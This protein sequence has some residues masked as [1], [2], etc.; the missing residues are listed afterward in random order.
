MKRYFSFFAVIF[1]FAITLFLAEVAFAQP[2]KISVKVI[3]AKTGEPVV[4]ATV[5]VVET[6]QGAYTKDNGVATIINVAPGQNYTV[7]AK[8]AGFELSTISNVKV[9]SNLTTNLEFK[10]ST[11][12]QKEI[13]VEARPIV[14]KSETK[15]GARFDSSS[16]TNVPGRKN[17]TDLVTLTPG[18]VAE[19]QGVTIAG[20]RSTSNSTRMG[21]VEITDIVDGNTNSIQS[22][23]ST[24]AVAELNVTTSGA[25]ASRGN[26]TGGYIESNTKSG[27]ASFE[28]LAHY[29]QEIPALFGSSSN[30][31]EL[32][33]SGN[34][35]LEVAFG[36]PIT[37]DAK[38]FVTVKGSTTDY[39]RNGLNVMDPYGNNLGQIDHTKQF[40]RAITA[41]LAFNDVFGFRVQADAILASESTQI[42][43]TGSGINATLNNIFTYGDLPQLPALNN[44]NNL[45]T[46]KGQSQIGEGIL[47]LTAGFETV[48]ERFG[49]YD[50]EAGG[51]LFSPYK[52]YTPKDEY[53][54]D[55]ITG[56][57]TPGKDGIMDNY[58]PVSKQIPDPRNPANALN[59]SGA[60]LNPFTGRIE[61]G[62]QNYTTNNPYGLMN[63]FYSVGNPAGY[64]EDTRQRIQVDGK[65]AQQISE[66][67]IT[68][69]F[70]GQFH[71]ITT[72]SNNL[73]WDANPFQDVYDVNPYTAAL[74]VI[75][76]ME[77]ADIT[78]NP[79]LRFDI[80]DPA[81]NTAIVDPYNPVDLDDTG[82]VVYSFASA[83]IQ[84]QLSPRLGITYAISEMTTFNFNYGLYF[85]QPLMDQ[86]LT[87]TGG[88]FYKVLQRGNQIIGNGNLKAERSTEIVVGFTTA[89]NDIL[90]MTVQGVYKD[91]RNQSGLLRISSP[92]LATGYTMYIDDQYGNAKS[93]MLSFDKR[94][95]DNYAI[96]FN[97]TYSTAKGTSSS[98]A[99]NYSRLINPP[100]GAETAVLPLQ[101]YPLG[102]DRPIVS[103]LIV[104]LAWQK[105]EGP[106]IFG[107]KL[108]ELFNLSFTTEYRDGTP[109][110]PEDI[111]GNQSGEFNSARRPAYF[112]TNASLSR[113]IPL[114]DIFGDGAG[115]T[116]IDLQLEVLNLFNRTQAVDVYAATGLGDDDGT[117]GNFTGTVV[118]KNDPT[119]ADGNQLDALGNLKYNTRWDLNKDGQVDLSE[120]QK[121]FTQYR[122]DNY[123][124]RTNYQVPLRTYFNVT[125]RF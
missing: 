54:Y 57:L 97:F 26:A 60:G 75:D 19:G 17:L 102:Y 45:F 71:H 88:D 87:N 31:Y 125:F 51:D 111:R 42:A 52:I 3:D 76:K 14:D 95:R 108:L 121:A 24:F 1:A 37:E 40:G 105:N 100:A 38:Y 5:Q 96:R 69:G 110:T 109:Y 103:Q 70:E 101:P 36:G 11:T 23:V 32:M 119:N 115:N 30:G 7:T 106:E 62:G 55:D 6:K 99:E 10:L 43:A 80:Y 117:N 74:Y 98:A 85:K 67:L 20:A 90:A 22:N 16:I 18:V 61:G 91:L 77:F 49:K 84:T 73:P 44:F 94:M 104:N 64:S 34:K 25:D 2:G 86:V 41:N 114:S 65:F 72:L 107:A 82:G 8:F 123:A 9:S 39:L 29:R 78:F 79:S 46:L 124:R 4:R 28:F 122:T 59:L 53:S 112:Q 113:T 92:S 118:F 68:A 81:N 15:Q 13:V 47:E 66:H 93:L 56:T 35:I 33:P 116:A 48:N 12:I 27:G 58:T 63:T 89:L 21:G 83:D 120:Q 50:Y